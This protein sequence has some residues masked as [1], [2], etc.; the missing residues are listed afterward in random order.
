MNW[1]VIFV[2][3]G[4]EASLTNL[5]NRSNI[6]AFIPLMEKI[7]K[8]KGEFIKV[9]VPMYPNYIFIRS[10]LDQMEFN[11]RLYIFK[12]Q[13]SGILKQL[14]IDK[15]GTSVLQKEEIVLME[16]MMDSQYIVKHS[17]GIIE[18]DRI[19]IIDGPLKGLESSIVR[20][21]RHKRLAYLN[22]VLLGRQIKI[23]LEILKKI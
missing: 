3:G 18:G 7:H 22:N 12:Q 21:D 2:K 16:K 8:K 4:K 1:Y 20:I 9:I 13:H 6:D 5:L 15:E 14:Q 11:Q 10:K 23:S 19:K 17:S